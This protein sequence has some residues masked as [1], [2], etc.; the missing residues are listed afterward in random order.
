MGPVSGTAV[1]FMIW[2]TLLFVVLPW[3]VTQHDG[4]VAGADPGAPQ[5]NNI[6]RKFLITT[7]ISAVVWVIIF[8]LIRSD[9]IS[10]QR[11]AERLTL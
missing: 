8:L 2:W 10:F 11:L 7:L 4:S 6:K 9:L 3:G 5:H 1:F